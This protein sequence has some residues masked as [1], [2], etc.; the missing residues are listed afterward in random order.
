MKRSIKHL[1][2]RAAFASPV[3]HLLLANAAVIV[4]F[5]RVQD[6]WDPNGLTIG[7]DL[8]DRYC[9][10]FAQHFHVVALRDLIAKL[11]RGEDVSRH[12]AITFDDGYR[13]NVE[14]AAP[15][16]ER[17]SLPATFFVTSGWVG[18]DVGPWWDEMHGLRHPWMT[19]DQVRP[20]RRAGF[21]IGAH[22]R[23]HVDL[24]KTTEQDARHEILG[25]RLEL[26]DR[27]AIPVDL[28]AF[29]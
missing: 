19:W 18:S 7:R 27:L 10:F 15:T 29:P 20:L 17:H 12:L 8:F 14:N 25:A 11:E 22:T 5:H 23:T 13:D 2:G 26:E 21:D 16:L 3:G 28:F 24:G 4:A 1:L 6:S 9:R